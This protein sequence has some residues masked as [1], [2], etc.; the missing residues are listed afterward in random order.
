MAV[1]SAVLRQREKLEKELGINRD[2]T[3]VQASSDPVVSSVPIAIDPAQQVPEPVMEPVAPVPIDLQAK[4]KELEQL[5]RTRDGQTSAAT[6]D[7]NDARARA[8]ATALQV[9]ALEDAVAALSTRAETAEARVAAKA[10]DESMPSLDDDG[11]LSPGE[12]ETFGADSVK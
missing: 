7:A 4:V 10:A 12:L 6:R 3:P 8:D 1:P 9:K 5:L 2:G 11:D